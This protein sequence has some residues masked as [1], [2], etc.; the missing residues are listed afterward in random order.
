MK[1][2]DKYLFYSIFKAFLAVHIGL[3]LILSFL[4]FFDEINEIQE[5]GYTI[6][7]ALKYVVLLMPSF[8]NNLIILSI[9]IG[10][11]FAIGRLNSNKEI[12]IFLTGAISL[13][14][15]IFKCLF[16]PFLISVIFI[17]FSEITAPKLA[18]LANNNKNYALG[19]AVLT[20]SD[21]FWTKRNNN[22]I[23]I[24]RSGKDN[25]FQIFNIDSDSSLLSYDFVNYVKSNTPPFSGYTLKFNKDKK[26]ISKNEISVDEN[27]YDEIIDQS[28]K[29]F[30][31][32]LQ[33]MSVI[34]LFEATFYAYKNHLKTGDYN[35][36]LTARF[37]RPFTLVGMI[38]ISLP[39]VLNFN[40]DVSI[41]KRVFIALTIGVITHLTT[42]ILS[43]LTIKF[44]FLEVIG[45]VIPTII[46]LSMGYVLVRVRLGFN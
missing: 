4:S 20:E 22:F 8:S 5:T 43:V 1:I 42:K 31:K 27:N 36:E 24:N 28:T 23:L 38:L 33:E 25:F 40:R 14:N 7:E 21:F 13:K 11:I 41:G 46:L 32:K 16:Y 44:A 9:M 15:I 18:H 30:D 35:N 6:N 3:V 34:E 19:K 10:T 17:I 39:F 45:I 2:L 12:Q 29:A 26:T 37:I